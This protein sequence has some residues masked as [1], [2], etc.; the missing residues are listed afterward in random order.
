MR[1]QLNVTTERVDD[2]PILL[3]HSETMGIAE[4]LD[5]YFK[6]HGNWAGMSLGWTTAVWLTHIL[7]EGDHRMNQ[8]QL[9]IAHRVQTLH[10]ST[11]QGIDERDWSDD[12]LAI[13]L[14]ALSQTQQWQQFETAL[15]QRIIRVYDLNP[16]RV[17]LDSTTA[18]GYWTVSEDGLFQFGYSKDHRPDLPQLKV[19]LSALDPLGLPLATQVVA[20][21]TADDPLYLPAVRQVSAS[22]GKHGV[23]YVGDCKMAALST[24][25][26]L[27][28]QG[29]YYLCPLASKQ[30]PEE[31]LQAYL[32]PVWAGERSL[33]PV[34]RSKDGQ[35][36]ELVAQGYEQTMALTG[37]VEGRPITWSERHLI[38]RSLKQAEAAS[39]ALQAR[40]LKA[41]AALMQLNE[42]RQGKKAYRDADALQQAAL[43][44]LKHHRVEGLLRLRI[45]E[46]VRER[47]VRAYGPHPATVRVEQ[48]FHLHAEIDE[49]AVTAAMRRF[50]WRVYATNH[51]QETLSLEQAVLAYREEYLVEHDFGRLKGKPLS[52]SPMYVQSDRRATG[53]IRLLSLGLRVLTLLEFRARQ[54]LADRH[55]TLPGLSVGNPKRTTSRPTAEALLKAFQHIHLSVVTLGQQLHRHITP[56]SEVQKHILSLWD[57]SPSLYDQPSDAF[58][59]P[60]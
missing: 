17:R 46:Q 40:L 51:P 8:V 31:V 48:T 16:Q 22:L 58:L 12:R 45:E 23:L 53:L 6:P 14:D 29:D 47:P 20:G 52:L 4:L 49:T 32:E 37:E 10:R 18:S 41:Q 11:G 34:Y 7:S 25:A 36:S 59:E 50:G 3:A 28:A 57:L 27:H 2:I 9:W 56:L 55:E 33:T 24:R 38:V 15:S 54:R 5:T 44:I 42:H 39:V 13:V 35:E 60:T 26:F 30:L 21:A 43:A 1:D 19:M